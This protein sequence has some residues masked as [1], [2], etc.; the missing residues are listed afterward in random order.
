M[1]SDPP[2]PEA[3]QD[4]NLG[5]MLRR[6]RLAAGLTQAEVAAIV[7]C[8]QRAVSHWEVGGRVPSVT[9]LAAIA[10]AFNLDVHDLIDHINERESA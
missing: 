2:S 4:E 9:Y 8:D 10:R 7:G 3:A 6:L 5:R 1:V